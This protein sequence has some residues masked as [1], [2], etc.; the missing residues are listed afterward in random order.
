M[1]LIDRRDLEVGHC[2]LLKSNIKAN[3]FSI[4]IITGIIHRDRSEYTLDSYVHMHIEQRMTDFKYEFRRYISSANRIV[5]TQWLI[6]DDFTLFE[7]T[8]VEALLHCYCDH[9]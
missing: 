2:Y 5:R 4:F 9:I 3:F 7:L 6:N 8:D 1:K